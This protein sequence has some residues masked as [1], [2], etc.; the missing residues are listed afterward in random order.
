MQ[1]KA[2]SLHTSTGAREYIFAHPAQLHH[3]GCRGRAAA[4]RP[5]AAGVGTIESR[6]GHQHDLLGS[7]T[8]A[9]G[10]KG[11][12][13]GVEGGS[14]ATQATQATQAARGVAGMEALPSPGDAG[15]TVYLCTVALLN[16]SP[17][18]PAT[19]GASTCVS[20]LP[21]E[22]A[23]TISLALSRHPLS[24]AR[25]PSQCAHQVEWSSGIG[26]IVRH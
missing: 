21:D 12:Q 4:Q 6:R 2:N 22:D 14:Q 16:A 7:L 26:A 11:G 23:I 17:M 1:K 9:A 5:A 20:R 10:V 13:K 25:V 15:N 8:V 19:A 18:P 24:S 3:P